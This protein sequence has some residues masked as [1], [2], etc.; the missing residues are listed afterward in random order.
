MKIAFT[1]DGIYAYAVRDPSALGGAELQQWLV[2][3]FLASKGWAVKVGV[4]KALEARRRETIENVE[5]VGIGQGYVLGDWYGFLRSERPDWWYWRCADH[6]WGPGV[7]IAR[8][9]KARTVFAAGLDRDVHPRSALYRRQRW[10]PLFAWGLQRSDRIL[11][12]HRGQFSELSHRWQGKAFVVP[13]IVP[14]VPQVR[15]HQERSNYVA[16]VAT[17]R[18]F[19]RPELLLEIARR[20]PDVR[21]IACGGASTFMSPPGYAERITASMQAQPNIEFRGN[22]SSQVAGDVIANAALFLSTS[23][24][25][26]YPNTF[27]QAWSCGTPVISLKVDPDEAIKQES[28][29]GVEADTNRVVDLI[30]ALLASSAKRDEIGHRARQYTARAHSEE[31]FGALFERAIRG[32]RDGREPGTAPASP[33]RSRAEVQ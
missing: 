9:A 1:S 12:Q 17:L 11:L 18:Q 5:F 30:R 8:L 27:L 13:N 2:A 4:R 28:L 3:R 33:T 20:A 32:V 26:G 15:P 21:F 25:E 22:V 14:S 24:V 6:L 29:G 23:D 10:W 7:E 31:T 16:W 19:K